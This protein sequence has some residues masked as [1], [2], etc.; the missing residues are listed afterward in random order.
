MSFLIKN[1]KYFCSILLVAVVFSFALLPPVSA[2]AQAKDDSAAADTGGLVSWMKG[3]AIL[4]I[5]S[6]ISSIFGALFGVVLWL[7]AMIIDYVLSPTNFP[8][9][10]AKIVQLGW[11]IT[12]DIANMFFILILLVIAFATVL[13]IDSYTIKQLWFKVLVA[14]LLINFSLVI[15]GFVID[16]TQ[17]LTTFFLKQAT[18]GGSFGTVTTRLASSMQILNFYNPQTGGIMGG[19]TQFGADATAAAIGIILTLVGLVVTVFVFGAT[20]I[21]LIIR[22]IWIWF[23][24][25]IAPL[26]WISWILP[27]TS[28]YFKQW[29]DKFINWTFF[30]PAYAFMIYLSLSLF[31]ANGKFL[32]GNLPSNSIKAWGEA[33]PGLTTIAM[34]AAIFQWILVIAMMFG[35]LIVAQK[36]GIGLATNAQKTL[37]SWGTDAKNWTGRQLRR[38]ALGVGAKSAT[39]TAPAKAGWLARGAQ[40][41]A[42]TAIPGRRLVAGQVFK[43]TAGEAKTVEEAQ[44]GF[45]DWTPDA[46]QAYLKKSPSSISSALFRNQQ[47][48]A[49]LALKE[50]GKLDKVGEARIKELAALASQQYP[51]Q[52][53]EILKVAPHLAKSYGKTI[54]EIVKKIDKAD[55]IMIDSLGYAQVAMNLNPQ[56]LKTMVQKASDNKIKILKGTIDI[57]F[58][59]LD[60][61]YKNKVN[62]E[63]IGKPDEKPPSKEMRNKALREITEKDPYAGKVASARF[64]T[65]SPAWEI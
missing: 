11:G 38:T 53:D 6:T 5:S 60:A 10:G 16:F 12:R 35:S 29:W 49:A 61:T 43:M 31:D 37:G 50:K 2:L 3:S 40:A 52:L 20:A 8:F 26:A 51:K 15:A 57:E 32:A 4:F 62:E 1:K 64:T 65:K 45:A 56:Q 39:D 48:A 7:E 14:A 44:K 46:I 36:F 41:L 27:S 21:F 24:L 25:I 19:L 30:A 59:A 17:V 18:G 63:V 28:G 22:I 23:L 55:E 33:A 58:N 34:P 9:V 13:R 47:M 54:E 42:G